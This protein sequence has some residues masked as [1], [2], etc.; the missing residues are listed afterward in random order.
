MTDK[1][2]TRWA[3]FAKLVDPVEK[4]TQFTTK[5]SMGGWKEEPK[6]GEAVLDKVV[7]PVEK[8]TKFTTKFST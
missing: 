1:R 3:G 8:P 4:P 6:E 5:L 7:D 2:P